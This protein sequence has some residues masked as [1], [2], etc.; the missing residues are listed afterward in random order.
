M[1]G[2]NFDITK[3][4]IFC[5][6]SNERIQLLTGFLVLYNEHLVCSQNMNIK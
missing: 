2:G 1:D 6:E 5:T 4:C 3:N